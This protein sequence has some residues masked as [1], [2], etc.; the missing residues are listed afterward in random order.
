MSAPGAFDRMVGGKGVPCA[1]HGEGGEYRR[2]GWCREFELLEVAVGDG[3]GGGGRTN[4]TN[5]R[6]WSWVCGE[7]GGERGRGVESC[8]G[9]GG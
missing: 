9:A 4:C 8:G 6:S 1:G 5:H 7:N 3:G 2:R